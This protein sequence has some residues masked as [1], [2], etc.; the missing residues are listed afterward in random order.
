MSTKIECPTLG[1]KEAAE[2]LGIQEQTLAVWRCNQRYPLPFIRVGRRIKYR[3]SDLDAFLAN[4][5]VGTLAD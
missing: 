2:Y 3:I 5:T 1:A 4:R